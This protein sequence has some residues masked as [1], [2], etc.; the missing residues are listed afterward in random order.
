MELLDRQMIATGFVTGGASVTS[1]SGGFCPFVTDR[2][3]VTKA[4]FLQLLQ[5]LVT[6]VTGRGG[7]NNID[8]A[9]FVTGDHSVTSRVSRYTLPVCNEHTRI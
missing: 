7:K 9:G 2:P 6:L 4:R 5:F 1:G 3:N 8:R